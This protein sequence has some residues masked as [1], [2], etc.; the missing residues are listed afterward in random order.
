MSFN[1]MDVATFKPRVRELYASWKSDYG[2]KAWE[3]LE[4]Y[5]GKLG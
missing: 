2:T 4:K 1:T 3:L 5:T